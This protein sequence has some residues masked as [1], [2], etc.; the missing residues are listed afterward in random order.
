MADQE[1]SGR[2][3]EKVLGEKQLSCKLTRQRPLLGQGRLTRSLGAIP[4]HPPASGLPP[5]SF[6]SG[7][8]T[9]LQTEK[10]TLLECENIPFCFYRMLE[11]HF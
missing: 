1:Q 10:I 3:R 7:T 6:L 8:N 2:A 4:M 11:L 5:S 9:G